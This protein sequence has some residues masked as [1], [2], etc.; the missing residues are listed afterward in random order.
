MNQKTTFLAH[1]GDAWFERNLAAVQR[2]P[3]PEG[4]QVLA[5]LLLVKDHLPPG[6]AVLEVG[7][8]PAVRLAWLADHWGFKCHGIDPSKKAVS[9]ARHLGID[10]R[11]GTADR[12]PFQDASFE[13]VIFG[14]C[15]YVCDR[16]DLFRVAAEADRV[17]ANPGWL[18]I[19]DFFSPVPVRRSYDHAPG[20]F[21]HKMDYASLF[22]WHP[23]YT[24]FA[25][26]V[27]HH[28]EGIYTDDP[29][30]WVST[31]VLRKRHQP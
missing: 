27:T 29:G 25:H 23:D 5:D 8:G 24:V 2:C 28:H 30:E 22:G 21:S 7:C 17:L 14:F 9:H 12:L 19:Q 4:D 16:E 13:L 20:L 3:L 18:V 10:A 31:T 15:L 11:V 6:S 26:R 1:E